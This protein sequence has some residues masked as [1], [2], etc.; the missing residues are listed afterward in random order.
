M[1]QLEILEFPDPRLRTVARPVDPAQ[2]TTP[3]FQSLLGDM[4]ETMYEAPGIGLAASQVDVHQR[5]MVI[6]VSEDRSQPLVFVNPEIL[7][8]DGEQVYQEGCLSVPGIF[9]D[10]TRANSIRVRAIGRDGAPFEM[11]ADGLLAVCIQHEMDHLAG[12]LFVDYLSP[13]KREMVR[14]KLAKRQR[15]SA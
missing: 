3:E 14:K 10:V 1:A 7:E 12:K 6:D 4:F 13:L 15:Q 9:A 2:V 8:R 11:Q 5:F